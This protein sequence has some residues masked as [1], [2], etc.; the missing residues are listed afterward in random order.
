MRA[1]GAPA[2]VY[3]APDVLALVKTRVAEPRR[4]SVLPTFRWAF[5]GL[6][7]AC[8]IVWL[9]MS[10]QAPP[11][12]G[13]PPEVTAATAP[14]AQ[15]P[16]PIC[17]DPA[18]PLP[19]AE[20]RSTAPSIAGVQPQRKSMPQKRSVVRVPPKPRRPVVNE[21][22]QPEPQP[23]IEYLVVYRPSG[24]GDG[25]EIARNPGSDGPEPA[26]SSYS[27]RMTDDSTGHVTTVSS[28][29]NPAGDSEE[30]ATVEFRSEPTGPDGDEHERSSTDDKPL[31]LSGRAANSDRC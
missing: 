26:S 25:I 5:A 21:A 9:A 31:D 4:R 3:P 22:E 19:T 18:K 20:V 13:A 7:A 29:S 24:L 17:S 8:G 27:I 6:A 10:L 16:E 12:N 2:T 1:L 14:S 15:Q 28:Y 23:E 30:S 11:Q